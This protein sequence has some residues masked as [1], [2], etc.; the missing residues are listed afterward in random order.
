MLG[1]IGFADGRRA[2]RQQSLPNLGQMPFST[3]QKNALNSKASALDTASPWIHPALSSNAN[4][5]AD[6]DPFTVTPNP[7]GNL[8]QPFVQ[9][10]APGAGPVTIISYSVPRSKIAFIRYLSIAWFGGNDPSGS[11]QV[12]WRVLKNGGGLRGLNQLT[13]TFGTFAAPKV[14]TAPII[15]VEN[16]TVSVTAEVP[17][18]FAPVSGGSG[19]AAT[20]DGFTL[21][22][23]QATLPQPGSY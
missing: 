2:V 20:F 16:D 1:R 13:A 12:I 22:I 10:L 9:L 19:T 5:P 21:S 8:A 17:S 18:G 15:A 11:G 7:S 4:A 14:L 6:S 23:S 3:V